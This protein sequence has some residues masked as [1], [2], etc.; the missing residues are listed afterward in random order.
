LNAQQ[1]TPNIQQPTAEE[2]GGIRLR[3]AFR[4]RAKRLR[5]HVT[6]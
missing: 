1:P 2:S 4:L 5:R 6:A 3:G